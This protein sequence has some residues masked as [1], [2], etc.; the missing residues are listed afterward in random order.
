MSTITKVPL[1]DLKAQYESIRDEVGQ[2]VANVMESTSFVNGPN[3]K[4]FELEMGDY[5]G[6]RHAIGVGSGTDALVLAL[7]AMGVGPGD[8]VIVPAFT[9]LATCSS[10][11]LLG[12]TPVLADID[13]D[14]YCI[15]TEQVAS[16]VSPRTKAIIPVHLFGHPVDLD[17]LLKLAAERNIRIVEDNAQAIGAS[18]KGRTT[19]SI[20]DV[21][22]LSFYPSKNLGAYG[23]GGMVLTND[24]GLA[25]VVTKL[26]S[27]GWTQKYYPEMVGYN[28]RLDEIQAAV[29]RVKLH[30]IDE[31]N[32]GRRDHAGK[33]DELLAGLSL[34]TPGE[35]GYGRSVY[36]LYVVEVDDRQRVISELDSNGIGNAVYY[37]YP[38]HLTPILASLGHGPGDFPVS[39]RAAERCLAIPLY[40]EMNTAQLEVV[41]DV[42]RKAV[43]GLA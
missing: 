2:A 15:D 39:E 27:H 10:A 9:F 11:M 12:A 28:S 33:Y 35:A 3:V 42:L 21:G 6:V 41:A 34:R 37:P 14:T 7:Q 30:H 17:P 18:Y 24:D 25:G 5:L 31:W 4:A 16:K 20:G 32:D 40:P 29:L 19:G 22:C 36:H 23:D 38:L 1:M 13:P 26:R 8:E 43:P